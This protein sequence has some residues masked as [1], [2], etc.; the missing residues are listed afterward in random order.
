MKKETWIDYDAAPDYMDA[1]YNEMEYLKEKG[2]KNIFVYDLGYGARI[3][4]ED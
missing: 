4:Y 1:A 3:E 2:Y